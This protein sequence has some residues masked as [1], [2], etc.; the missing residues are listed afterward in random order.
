MATQILAKDILQKESNKIGSQLVWQALDLGNGYDARVM[1]NVEV[2]N[3]DILATRHGERTFSIT[4]S[5][6]GVSIC[7]YESDNL[8]ELVAISDKW[9]CKKINMWRLMEEHTKIVVYDS[10]KDLLTLSDEVLLENQ[11]MRLLKQVETGIITFKKDVFE[12]LVKEF[13]NLYGIVS[14]DFLRFSNV[15]GGGF[16]Y[17][18]SSPS[19][20][21]R[22]DVICVCEHIDLDFSE[23]D[24][25]FR[26]KD[27]N[28]AIHKAKEMFPKNYKP[29]FNPLKH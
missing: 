20:R 28:E 3:R 26:T 14:I 19:I 9:V 24:T 27:I 4:I 23:Y 1:A 10:C 12:A 15:I 8:S 5:A 6:W 22:E 16:N 18:F 29:A 2:E 25:Y 13:N 21:C 11:W 17:K 7:K